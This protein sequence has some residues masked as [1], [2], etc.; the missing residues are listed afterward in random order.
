MMASA[1]GKVMLFGEYGVLEGG[2]ALLA[3]INRRAQVR[4]EPSDQ[5]YVDTCG[6]L[7]QTASFD[8]PAGRSA[9][10]WHNPDF[11]PPLKLFSVVIEN[12]TEACHAPVKVILDTTAFFQ[13]DDKIGIGSSAA[14]CV[15]L[16]AL[17]ANRLGQAVSLDQ[18][19]KLHFEFQKSGSGADVAACYQGG[20]ICFSRSK[21]AQSV[22]LPSGLCLALTWTG[23][24]ASTTN[25]LDQLAD[26][27]KRNKPA[28]QGAMKALQKTAEAVLSQAGAGDWLLALGDFVDALE[29]F[30][31]QTGLTIFLSPHQELTE[32]ARKQ[33]LLY[34]PM[35][36]GAGDLGLVA[37]DDPERLA[38]FCNQITEKGLGLIDFE[39]DQQGVFCS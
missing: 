29:R 35:G 32:L 13:G 17:W 37:T 25:M 34:K 11:G 8:L 33:G 20:V 1:P 30:S 4:L 3:A 22:K 12:F 14:L 18:C 24:S 36:A 27:R 23:L 6:W 38:F 7:P 26:Y 16:A 21:P 5:Y 10:V 9:P 39:I 19:Q 28:Y 2:R 15:A 31:T